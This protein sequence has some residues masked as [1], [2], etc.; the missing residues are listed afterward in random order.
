MSELTETAKRVSL[1]IGRTY[2]FLG[3]GAGIGRPLEV[4]GKDGR[5]RQAWVYPPSLYRLL[6]VALDYRTAQKGVIYVGCGGDHDEGQIHRACLFDW[7]TQFELVNDEG[8]NT[9]GER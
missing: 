7:Y 6:G 3:I 8:L 4:T 5:K 1:E 2:K 9:E